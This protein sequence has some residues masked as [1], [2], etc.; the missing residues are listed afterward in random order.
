MLC[1]PILATRY[2]TVTDQIEDGFDGVIVGLDA[3]ALANGIINTLLDENLKSQ[4]VNNLK[5][6][7]FSDTQTIKKYMELFG[8]TKG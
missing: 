7:D 4:L 8:L 6:S 1:R 3:D 2:P 5:N